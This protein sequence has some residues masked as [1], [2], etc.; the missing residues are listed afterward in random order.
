MKSSAVATYK[1]WSAYRSHMLLSL[2]VGPVF[3]LVQSS[4]WKAV[5]QGRELVNGLS[6]EQMLT[7]FAAATLIYYLIMDFADWN[8]QMLIRTGK[9]ITF[10][11]RPMSHW[12]FAFSQ[13]VGHRVLG[14][15]FEFLPVYLMFLFLFKIPLIPVYPLWFLLSISLSFIMMFQINYC[16]GIIGFWLVQAEG[17]RRVFLIFRDILAGAFLPLSFFP[18]LF[19]KILFF[20]PF[21]F[22]SYVPLRVFMGNYELAGFEMSIPSIVG[23]QALAVLAMTGITTLL[24]KLGIKRFTGVGV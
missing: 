14:L 24:W 8:L 10:I 19:Q 2:V 20:L 7:Y 4:I 17:I 3:F 21:Q 18:E 11:I 23:I 13:K 12:F 5:F 15:F 6:L 16:V 9:F 1:E 22:I